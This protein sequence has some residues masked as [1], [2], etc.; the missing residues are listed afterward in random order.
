M[1]YDKDTNSPEAT[2]G[3]GDYGEE[4]VGMAVTPFVEATRVGRFP[5]DNTGGDRSQGEVEGAG[6]IYSAML[7]E[8]PNRSRN[9]D[10]EPSRSPSRIGATSVPIVRQGDRKTGRL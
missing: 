3:S 4:G 1:K 2:P 6:S 10:D 9:N 5:N 8:R 7:S